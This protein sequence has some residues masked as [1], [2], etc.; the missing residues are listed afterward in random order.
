MNKKLVSLLCSVFFLASCSR[1]VDKKE[2]KNQDVSSVRD[3]QG[4]ISEPIDRNTDILDNPNTKY[5]SSVL[6]VKTSATSDSDVL[7][8]DRIDLGITSIE[9]IAHGSEWKKAKL[10]E[11]LDAKS[12]I[13]KFRN[14]KLFNRV[15]F[16]YI[17]D[18]DEV[19][20]S[21]EGTTK[22]EE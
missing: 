22:R 7:T 3:D 6:L 17:Y 20:G 5:D 14:S 1:L 8:K 21:E 11:G 4:K 18:T 16:D 12:S 13:K 9:S 15:D 19:E 2:N 10:A